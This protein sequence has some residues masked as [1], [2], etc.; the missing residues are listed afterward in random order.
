MTY[1]FCV[2]ELLE[3]PLFGVKSGLRNM[4]RLIEA[5]DLKHKDYKIIHVAG[6]NGKGSTCSMIASILESEG[7]Q[8][9][10]FTSP[11]LVKINERIQINHQE[12][13]DDM[14][15]EAYLKV[16]E[17]TQHLSV[18]HIYPTF[19]ETIFAIALCVFEQKRIEWLV[20]ETGLGGRLDATNAIES[21][22]MAVITRIG[23]DHMHV[24]G[25]TL[26]AIAIEKAGIMREG[27][28]VVIGTQTQ[29]VLSC[30]LEKARVIGAQAV[31]TESRTMKILRKT[32]EAIDFSIDNKYYR[33]EV[34]SITHAPGYQV[35]N[36]MTVLAAMTK[37]MEDGYVT[38][39][40]IREGL[41]NFYWPGRLEWVR[42][43]LL[44]EGAH[45]IDGILAF[46]EYIKEAS[47]ESSINL[48]YTSMQD[49]QYQEIIRHL[50]YLPRLNKVYIADIAFRKSVEPQILVNEF[51]KHHV[52][53]E[54]IQ[55]LESI[56]RDH[57]KG[58]E[59]EIICCVGSLYLVGEIKRILGGFDRD[60][61]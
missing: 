54:I 59:N 11:H 19:F 53:P 46:C 4:K 18:E 51:E 40:G 32:K 6:T 8:V 60:Q 33:N 22:Y 43:W 2:K 57:N 55:N 24:L 3:I 48:V 14:F 27:T 50:A 42:P 58:D 10:L 37:L 16:K 21:K 28:R 61:F 44:L 20:L 1:E 36:T 45:N 31:E 47:L 12:V 26:E 34:L 15:L 35:E 41:L 5:L 17:I 29:G 7:Y 39:K 23:L 52:E 25:N 9:G 13:D 38:L 49:K 56:I 30:L